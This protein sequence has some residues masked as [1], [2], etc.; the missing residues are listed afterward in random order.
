VNR[1]SAFLLLACCNVG[2]AQ[3]PQ[4]KSGGTVYIE[5]MDGYEAYLAAAIVKKHVPLIVVADES[6]AQYIIRGNVSQVAPTHPAVVINN[7]N[8][9]SAGN[10]NAFD[11]GFKSGFPKA[12]SGSGHTSASVSVIDPRTSQVLFA[13]S[14]E[15]VRGHQMQSDAEAFAKHLKEFIEKPKK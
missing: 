1:L 3:T 12:G 15:K 11:R 2:L 10:D 7:T 9:A 13:Y 14:V 6:K 4:I 5:P 8:T